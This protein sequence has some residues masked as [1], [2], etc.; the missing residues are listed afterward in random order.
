MFNVL[1]SEV[2]VVLLMVGI[3]YQKTQLGGL[4]VIKNTNTCWATWS[5]SHKENHHWPHFLLA[6][7]NIKPCNYGANSHLMCNGYQ[8]KKSCCLCGPPFTTGTVWQGHHYCLQV[9]TCDLELAD[10]LEFHWFSCEIFLWG[11]SIS[12]DVK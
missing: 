5:F 1:T 6:S 9:L 10:T 7:W 3:K 4:K 11:H 8:P 2:Y 12:K